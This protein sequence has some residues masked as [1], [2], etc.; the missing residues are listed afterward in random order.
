MAKH[1][2]SF[3]VHCR[4]YW[5]KAIGAACPY[6][7]DLH[8]HAYPSSKLS[9][10]TWYLRKSFFWGSSHAV[11]IYFKLLHLMSVLSG[12][13]CSRC[14]FIPFHMPGMGI[15]PGAPPAVVAQSRAL[16]ETWYCSP[17]HALL[18]SC[19]LAHS[20]HPPLIHRAC[21]I[22]QAWSINYNTATT[23]TSGI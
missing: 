2:N 4:W 21:L 22:L 18:V 14:S 9:W 13:F 6:L 7:W 16:P 3:G 10:Q 17:A 8:F 23:V 19:Q 1:C 20:A 5:A 11:L 15:P 12:C